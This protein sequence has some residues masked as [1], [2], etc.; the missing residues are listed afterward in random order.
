M[1]NKIGIVLAMLLIVFTEVFALENIIELPP[2]E[3]KS[4]MSVLEAISNRR[5]RRNF[6]D[7]PLTL[8]QVSTLLWACQGITDKK[9]GFRSA[10]SAGATYPLELFLVVGNVDGLKSGVY[11]YLPD[12]HGLD[13]VVEDDVRLLLTSACLD[14]SFI[15]EAPAT[16]VV[17]AVFERTT[18]YYGERGEMYVFQECGHVGE[19]LHLACEQMGLGTVMVGAFRD[20]AVKRIINMRKNEQPIYV[21]PVGY[22]K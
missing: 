4:G 9:R 13:I 18:R 3:I 1:K 5:S 10:P 16:I 11:R 20:D 22:P 15:M 21:M 19:N 2:P 6:K 7:T 8:Q 12:K 14:Q 17:G